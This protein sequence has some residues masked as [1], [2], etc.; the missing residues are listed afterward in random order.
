M[1]HKES[2]K[3][4]AFSTLKGLLELYPIATYNTITNYISRKKLPFENEKGKIEKLTIQ[5]SNENN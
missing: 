1:T 3:L 5:R 2:G 4:E